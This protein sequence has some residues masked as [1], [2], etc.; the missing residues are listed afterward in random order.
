MSGY[1]QPTYAHDVTNGEAER[2][3]LLDEAPTQP[4]AQQ[5]FYEQ[6][7][8]AQAQQQQHQQQHQQ[9]QLPPPPTKPKAAPQQAK[10][11]VPQQQ[12]LYGRPVDRTVSQPAR[13]PRA[14]AGWKD[15][16]LDAGELC[17]DKFVQLAG[18]LL[19]LLCLALI[20]MI[21]RAYFVDVLPL[22]NAR[23]CH[24]ASVELLHR[25]SERAEFHEATVRGRV[26]IQ[27][28]RSGR[29]LPADPNAPQASVQEMLQHQAAL[30]SSVWLETNPCAET[31]AITA[32]G[33][34]LL[35][36]ILFH[37]FATM[38]LGP[39]RPPANLSVEVEQHLA[40]HDPEVTR[41]WGAQMSADGELRVRHCATCKVV[42]PMRAHHCRACGACGLKM[43]HH[44]PWVNTCVGWR[45]HRHFLSFLV[46]LW[47]GCAFFLGV[48]ADSA[49]PVLFRS[50]RARDSVW[51]VV[52]ALI[53]ALI[54]LASSL[55]LLWSGHLLLSNQT[56][57]E[58]YS[59]QWE[60]DSKP[61]A[62]PSTVLGNPYDLG[63]ARNVK[64]VFGEQPL[65]MLLLPS[66]AKP[67]GSDGIIFPLSGGRGMPLHY[68]GDERAA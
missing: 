24:G 46:F 14:P 51:L 50:S 55:F 15:R 34:Y 26:G 60:E 42:K 31:Y 61:G 25:Y 66:L 62:R 36:S 59:N 35:L 32:L 52:S 20:A 3:S 21:T 6:Q 12:V 5:Q 30:L 49:L 63:W 8:A 44:C 37:Y 1:P 16:C 58:F 33:I 22:L 13:P 48:C 7:K 9:Q 56:T 65:L 10:V 40:L 45:N 2:Q 38:L 47:A 17:L 19:T 57:I 43:D 39:G 28:E 68:M 4:L 27:D 54:L 29:F 18:P 53:C 64:L 23:V 41:R 11:L 67:P